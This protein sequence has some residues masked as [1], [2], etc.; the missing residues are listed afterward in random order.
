MRNFKSMVKSVGKGIAPHAIPLTM[1][2][3]AV[4]AHA[5][6]TQG[7]TWSGSNT[8]TI[9]NSQEFDSV[10]SKFDAW[11]AGSYGKTIALGATISGLAAAAFTKTLLPAGW[12]VGVGAAAVIAPKVIN[13]FFTA[14]I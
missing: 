5:G 9:A 4:D 13:A 6:T 11:I 14:V 7:M 10:G 3:I 2:L 8:S 12:G 1:M